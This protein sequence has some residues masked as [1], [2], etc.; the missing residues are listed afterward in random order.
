MWY[1]CYIGEIRMFGGNYAP[2]GWAFCH[3]Q[4]LRIAS[5]PALYSLIGNSYG[6]DGV[7]T[8]A[9]P[10]L[11]SLVPVHRSRPPLKSTTIGLAAGTAD[12]KLKSPP[13]LCVNFI[14]SLGGDYPSDN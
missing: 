10:D 1:D 4:Q 3:G 5:N 7:S 8:F 2:E 13:S 9:L 12:S 14:I 11:R 6:G